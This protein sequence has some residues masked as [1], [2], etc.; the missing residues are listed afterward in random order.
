MNSRFR[1]LIT[2]GVLFITYSCV[3]LMIPPDDCTA[4]FS[5][6]VIPL[7]I[8][9]AGAWLISVAVLHLVRFRHWSWSAFVVSWLFG[10][11]LMII[12][13]AV[14][15]VADDPA[16]Y[17]PHPS[18]ADVVQNRFVMFSLIAAL[19]GASKLRWWS[20]AAAGFSILVAQAAI[21]VASEMP[22]ACMY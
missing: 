7:R 14:H 11:G 17:G 10:G 3:G 19:F 1:I 18:L 21:S 4:H 2:C 15:V 22:W 9:L 5:P 16:A 20:A 12:L 13:I 8:V 6:I